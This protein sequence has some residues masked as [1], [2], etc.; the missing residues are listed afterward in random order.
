[1]S[2]YLVKVISKRNADNFG[3]LDLEANDPEHALARAKSLLSNY[4]L[5]HFVIDDGEQL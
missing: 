4:K 5:F 2:I 1:M 3:W